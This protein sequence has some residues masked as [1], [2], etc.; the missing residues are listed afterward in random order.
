MAARIYDKIENKIIDA[1]N[2]NFGIKLGT[3]Y[4]NDEDDD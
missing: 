2:E 3:F 4:R 1:N